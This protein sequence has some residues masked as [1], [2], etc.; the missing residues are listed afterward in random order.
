MAS[1]ETVVANGVPW[2]HCDDADIGLEGVWIIQRSPDFAYRFP[3]PH[4]N[5][6][7]LFSAHD[8]DYEQAKDLPPWIWLY[9]AVLAETEVH[10][11]FLRMVHKWDNIV[12]TGNGVPTERLG[13]IPLTNSPKSIFHACNPIRGLLP[14]L[15]IFRRVHM[16]DPEITLRVAFGM[17]YLDSLL[18]CGK[19][20]DGMLKRLRSRIMK[21]LDQP[22]VE[23][24]GR[25]STSYDVWC[26]YAKAGVFVYPTLFSEIYCAAVVES[27]MMG[28][29]PIVSPTMALAETTRHGIKIAGDVEQDRMIQARFVREILGLANNLPLQDKIRSEMIP[30]V[31][32]TYS[33]Q[34]MVERIV[35][36]AIRIQEKKA[37]PIP[38]DTNPLPT[39][40]HPSEVFVC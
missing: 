38:F 25:L 12:V 6:I 30:D 19:D 17:E 10:A 34:S 32:A 37:N 1:K 31:R 29:I 13:E 22:G 14:L 24:L 2:S 33:F 8:I 23:W 16:E 28:A 9:D 21:E 40:K 7:L 3:D 20:S 11:S 15:T 27:Q 39:T 35:A 36:L 18:H 4:P 26:E 5:Q